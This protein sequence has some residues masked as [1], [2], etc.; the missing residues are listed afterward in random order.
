M[1]SMVE[2]IGLA[3]DAAPLHGE[4]D[5]HFLAI[6]PGLRLSL[7]TLQAIR[8]SKAGVLLIVRSD[9]KDA[10]GAAVCVQ[11]STCLV[12][13]GSIDADRG[14]CAARPQAWAGR[15]IA[16]MDCALTGDVSRRYCRCG[17][18]LFA[19]YRFREP[20][21]PWAFP[22]RSCTA[23]ARWAMPAGSW[24]TRAAAAIPAA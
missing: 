10:D 12:P 22:P 7:S 24:W 4:H 18:G 8:Q 6:V 13:R 5:F 23:C 11:Y 9:T 21:A 16:R 2:T 19:L 20:R 14:A 3:T 15:Q 17:A 1:Q